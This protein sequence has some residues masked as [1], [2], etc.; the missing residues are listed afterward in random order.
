ME[1][2]SVTACLPFMS[3]LAPPVYRRPMAAETALWSRARNNSVVVA[4]PAG[5]PRVK[6]CLERITRMRLM[7]RLKRPFGQ[8]V[9]FK[10]VPRLSLVN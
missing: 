9:I 4:R 7:N 1:D 3:Y 5:I 2:R 10:I 8:W 6:W